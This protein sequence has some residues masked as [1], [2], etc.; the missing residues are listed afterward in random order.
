[1]S[2]Q[3]TLWGTDNTISLPELE[4]SRSQSDG[5]D[6]STSTESGPAPVPVSRFR[7]RE[8]DRA[9]PTPD[10]CGPLF[11]SSSPSADLQSALAS[12]LAANWDLNGSP[13]FGLTWKEQAM[14]SGLPICRLVAWVRRTSGGDCGGWRTPSSTDGER[15]KT[16]NVHPRQII[17]LNTMASWA[18]PTARDHEDGQAVENVPENALLGRQCHQWQTPVAGDAQGVKYRRDGGDPNKPR[19]TNLGLVTGWPTPNAGPDNS[20]DTKWQQRREK[21]KA[22]K[23]NGNGFGLTVGMAAQLSCAETEK[24]AALNPAFVRWLMGYPLAWDACGATATPSS[25]K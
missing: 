3:M 4:D 1:M 17:S 19:P 20:T 14:P 23:K 25:R 16:N 24:P 9:T 21:I 11:T 6:T 18:T 10:T 12:R 15:G 22:E 13:E 2:A 5:P 7:A 8:K